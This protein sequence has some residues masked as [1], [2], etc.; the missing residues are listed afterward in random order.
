[1][2]ILVV[3]CHP[4]NTSLTHEISKKF[5]LGLEDGGHNVEILDLYESHFNPVL[6][7][8]NEPDWST[9]RIVV[10][11]DIKK[12]MDRMNRV[13]G[14]AMIFPVWWYGMPAMMKGYIDKVWQF[15]YAY[16]N[17]KLPHDRIQWIG[18]VGTKEA[19]FK[20]RNYDSHL[21]H[22]LNIGISQYSGIK[23]FQTNLLYGTLKSDPEDKEENIKKHLL[24]A[25][26]LGLNY[27]EFTSEK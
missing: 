11:P 2:E 21:I 10:T 18:L 25:Y 4:R 14:L 12:E 27:A 8:E 24:T 26:Q 6:E 5:I 3:Y 20:K 23:N 1:M 9:D 15:N 19:Q 17:R 16:G 22:Q 13:D 7:E